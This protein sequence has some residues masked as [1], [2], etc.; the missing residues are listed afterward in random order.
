MKRHFSLNI[1]FFVQ[2]NMHGSLSQL[3]PD[4]PNTHTIYDAEEEKHKDHTRKQLHF[5]YLLS[6][7][8]LKGKLQFSM[9]K[10]YFFHKSI[11]Y[12]E[13]FSVSTQLLLS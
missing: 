1:A 9:R 12:V 5:Y 4:L 8:A 6:Q 13:K 7:K 10:L 11:V 3:L 2:F